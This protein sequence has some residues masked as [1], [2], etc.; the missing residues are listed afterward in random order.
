VIFSLRNT[1]NFRAWSS[2]NCFATLSFCDD[3]GSL[4][5][6]KDLPLLAAFKALFF[7]PSANSFLGYPVELD[8]LPRLIS[9]RITLLRVGEVETV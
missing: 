4:F 6:S 1:L 2:G 9:D 7:D 8:D 5:S 3:Y